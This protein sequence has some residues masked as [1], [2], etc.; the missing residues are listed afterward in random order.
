[1]D[2]VDLV[3]LE[4]DIVRTATYTWLITK[5]EYMATKEFDNEPIYNV[6]LER[7]VYS[8]LKSDKG[9]LLCNKISQINTIFDKVPHYTR[10][11]FFLKTIYEDLR[12]IR[13]TLMQTKSS[14]DMIEIMSM[15]KNLRT[16][17]YSKTPV[18]CTDYIQNM[19]SVYGYGPKNKEITQILKYLS[20]YGS[21]YIFGGF[22]RDILLKETVSEY[23]D[24]DIVVD[25]YDITMYKMLHTHLPQLPGIECTTNP[26]ISFK[27]LPLELDI[28]TLQDADIQRYKNTRLRGP[29]DLIHNAHMSNQMIA[30]EINFSDDNNSSRC[31]YADPTYYTTLLNGIVYE[32]TDYTRSGS[33]PYL[34]MEHKRCSI[35]ETKSFL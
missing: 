28:F 8:Y 1:M 30:M 29:I 9:E 5:P 10:N 15:Y 27:H 3:A 14:L 13:N 35:I 24:I 18:L 4:E 32:N 25:C 2:D 31:I 26:Y 12:R 16:F 34:N 11:M 17:V 33:D 21:V 23:K 6:T 22:L 19:I 20:T 7:N